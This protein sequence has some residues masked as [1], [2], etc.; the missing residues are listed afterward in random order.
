MVLNAIL[1]AGVL[2]LG[3]LLSLELGRRFGTRK[4]AIDPEGARAGSG[5]VEGA[6]FA[7]FGLLVAFTFS[8][9]ASRFDSRRQLVVEEAND[10]GTAYLRLDLL[11]ADAQPALRDLFRTYLDSRIQTYQ[12]LPDLAAAEKELAH[13][14]TLQGEIWSRAV[15]ACRDQN[16]NATTA[17]VLASLNTMIDIVTT[18]TMVARMHPPP[19]MFGLLFLLGLGCAFMAGHGMAGGKTRS[20]VHVLGFAAVTAITVYVILDTEFPRFG[21]IRIDA[22]DQV[23][24]DLRQTM[25]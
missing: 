17:L 2:F 4:L 19:I 11:P 13:S 12:K 6:V 9:A 14:L 16:N 18:R 8:G 7:L 25:K 20:W 15:A 10:I 22:V 24:I 21:F 5:T 3:M 1:F 23:L